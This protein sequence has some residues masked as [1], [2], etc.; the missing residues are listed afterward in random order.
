[1]I[2]I[3]DLTRGQK[4]EMFNLHATYVNPKAIEKIFYLKKVPI[5]TIDLTAISKDLLYHLSQESCKNYLEL[6]KNPACKY[7]IISGNKLIDGLHRISA[8]IMNGQTTIEV[9]DFGNLLNTDESGFQFVIKLI[10]KN[11]YK[12]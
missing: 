2:Q 6:L 11:T 5:K 10:Q 7:P 8:A 12:I 4:E 9:L 3:N 1:M